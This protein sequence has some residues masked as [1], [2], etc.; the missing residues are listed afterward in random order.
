MPFHQFDLNL[1]RI[2]EAL[3]TEAH[4]TRAA[5]KVFLSQSA[6]SH[7]LNRLRNQLNDPILVRSRNGLQPTPRALSLLG[8]VRDVLKRLEQALS[9]PKAF[10]PETSNRTFT[11]AVTDYFEAVVFPELI[12]TLEQKAPNISFDLEMIG[13][14][15]SLERLENGTVDL[16]IGVEDSSKIANH[17]LVKPWRLE[18]PVCLVGKQFKDIPEQL[19][20]KQYLA[21]PHIVM[22]DQID[23][24]PD[25]LDRW[26]VEHNLSRHTAI[27][28][29]NYLAAARALVASRLV[30]TLPQHMAEMYMQWL[31]VR[32]L[33]APDELP[34]WDM[35]ILQH[36]L[37]QQDTGVEWLFEHLV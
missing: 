5:E 11:L 9:P 14:N 8:E 3:V 15:S 24:K 28:M 13:P 2:F 6:T 29:V 18:K 23:N 27:R 30:L 10:V 16:V 31:P 25:S 12:P 32:M 19:T 21:L 17:L 1:L 35:K 33:N 20:L 7:A 4:V 36:P 22:H 26:L 37:Y 34:N